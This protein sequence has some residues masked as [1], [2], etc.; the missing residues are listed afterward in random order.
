MGPAHIPTELVPDFL[1]GLKWPG[2]EVD[3]TLPSSAEVKNEW[4]CTYTHPIRLRGMD[5]VNFFF[6]LP[7]PPEISSSDIRLQI[8]YIMLEN[9]PE[10]NFVKAIYKQVS[11]YRSERPEITQSH[12]FS[13][14]SRV[15][16][17]I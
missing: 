6:F 1:P 14:L 2:R 12:T 7:S 3:S 8:L 15:L 13:T 5:R 11:S 16:E 10:N 4:S 9:F 17:T